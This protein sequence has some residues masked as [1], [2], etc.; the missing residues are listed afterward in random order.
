MTNRE[1]IERQVKQLNSSDFAKFREWFR[2]YEWQQWDR[3]IERD[4][5]TGRLR[6]LPEKALSDHAAGR[7]KPI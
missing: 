7:T 1:H 3:Q 5:Q 4:S 6:A 2:E